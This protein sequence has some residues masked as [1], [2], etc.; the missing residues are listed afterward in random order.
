MINLDR[1][2]ER[3][4]AFERRWAAVRA[5]GWPVPKR[6]AAL[7]GAEMVL[8]PWW[9]AGAAAWGCFR[10]H[11]AV[12]EM[13]YRDRIQT[14]AVFEDDAVFADDFG[15]RW[16]RFDDQLPDDL[17]WVYLGGQHIDRT[18][19]VPLK[20]SEHVY[21]PHNVHRAHAYVI[22]RPAIQH[23]VEH[24]WS[25]EA[26]GA[27]GHVDHRFGEL[28]AAMVGV[29]CPDRWL[30]GQAA[31]VSNIKGKALPENWFPDSI[32]VADPPLPAGH[33]PAIVVWGAAG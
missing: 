19:G 5:S 32:D 3:W 28:H 20:I 1:D 27:R 16:R 29:Y 25:R 4:S 10:S 6:F 7:D 23:V 26:W 18:A 22:R 13:A 8:P 33:A 30:V 15:Q 24:L 9:R 11:L 12:L 17:R 31:G 21:Q 14:L 2:T